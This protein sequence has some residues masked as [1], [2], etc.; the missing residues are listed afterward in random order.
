MK[1]KYYTLPVHGAE[2]KRTPAR[3][4]L[5]SVPVALACLVVVAWNRIT[6]FL[7]PHTPTLDDVFIDRAAEELFLYDFQF[8]L[9]VPI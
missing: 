5:Y 8:T 7:L 9:L 2:S 6:P 3:R 4:T 1:N